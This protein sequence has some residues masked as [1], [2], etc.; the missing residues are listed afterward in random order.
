MGRV[1]IATAE[2]YIS[3]EI[4]ENARTIINS[5]KAAAKVGARLVHFPEA[6]L[7]GYVKKQ[8]KCWKDVDWALAEQMKAEIANCCRENNIWA[9]FG[10]AHKDTNQDRPFNSLFIISDT[11]KIACRY[12]KRFC[13]HTEISDWFSAGDQLVLFEVDEVK[14]GCV[15]CIEIQ[16]PEVFIEYEK[17]ATDCILFSSYSDTAMF[18]TQAQGHAACNNLWISIS[19]PQNCPKTSSCFIG[20]DGNIIYS[21][22]DT[23]STLIYNEIN[24]EDASW[25]IP[26]KKARPWRRLARKGEIYN[27]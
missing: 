22:R 15:L 8:I 9:V 2:T 16:F 3:A 13:S 4:S 21:H 6:S 14:F 1:K 27:L 17:L 24:T 25:D 12:D 23:S 7:T 5:I 26:L 19:S 20:P 11:G 18:E 10:S